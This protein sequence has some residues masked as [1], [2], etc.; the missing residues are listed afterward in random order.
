MAGIFTCNNRVFDLWIMLFFGII[1]F[2]MSRYGFP[3]APMILGFILGPYLE[4][5]MVRANQLG[6][7]SLMPIFQRQIA[8]GFLI[9]MAAFVVFQIYTNVKK[10]KAGNDNPIEDVDD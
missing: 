3:T 6:R 2:I 10:M 5:Y 9:V 7:G 4:T 1:A 8:M